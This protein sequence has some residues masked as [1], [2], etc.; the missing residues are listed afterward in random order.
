MGDSSFEDIV[1]QARKLWLE[2]LSKIEIDV[3]NTPPNVT[4]MLY[5]SLY[6]ASL[7]PVCCGP[8][9]CGLVKLTLVPQNNA[10]G[11]TQGVFADTTSFYFDSLYCRFVF[12]TL[13]ELIIIIFLSQLGHGQSH[14][15]IVISCLLILTSQF[16]TFYPLMGLHSPVE[17]AQIV[18]NYIDGW[19][20]NGWMPECRA[21]NLPG[22]TQGGSSADNIVSHFAVNYHNEA[23]QLGIELDELYAALVTDGEVNPPEWNIEGRQVN[24]Y[25]S[26]CFLF[27]LCGVLIVP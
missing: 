13:E 6:R 26:V 10:T 16:R 23:K 17:F 3:V 25:K 18:D 8:W 2:K 12:M 19:R 1:E 11:E 27:F 20:K 24:V 4:E 14:R 7:T 22:W 9:R 21:N 5:S 15:S